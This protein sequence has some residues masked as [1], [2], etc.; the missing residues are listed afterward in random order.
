MLRNEIW[1]WAIAAVYIDV[2]SFLR[3][4]VLKSTSRTNR[5]EGLHLE[6]AFK[7]EPDCAKWNKHYSNS[8][9]M[10]MNCLWGS[11]IATIKKTK[12]CTLKHPLPRMHARTCIIQA[13][14]Q[15]NFESKKSL[16][17]LFNKAVRMGV[18]LNFFYI[19]CQVI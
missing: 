10:V 2:V 17:I 3:T 9:E 5:M 6:I 16:A 4:C 18:L 13:H 19:S 7:T 8:H 15:I 14:L 11:Y 12:K 1:H